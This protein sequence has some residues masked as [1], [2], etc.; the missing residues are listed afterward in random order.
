[1]NELQRHGRRLYDAVNVP[2][3]PFANNGS[4]CHDRAYAMALKAE[5]AGVDFE[6]AY[7]L[8]ASDQGL[9]V[10]G[11]VPWTSHVVL[12]TP[13]RMIDGAPRRLFVDPSLFEGGPV[14]LQQIQDR[15]GAKL[16][17]QAFKFGAF[18]PRQRPAHQRDDWEPYDYFGPDNRRRPTVGKVRDNLR[19]A[20]RELRGQAPMPGNVLPAEAAKPSDGSLTVTTPAPVKADTP[21]LSLVS[22]VQHWACRLPLGLGR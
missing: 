6:M 14:G 1:M 22:R 8:P 20:W 18:V 9:Q 17:W 4:Y 12:V 19:Q 11:H 15:L 2:E 21:V 16:E 13:E 10:D 7:F 5:Q 3:I